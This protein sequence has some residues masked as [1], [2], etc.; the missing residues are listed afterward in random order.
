MRKAGI[1][2]LI[3]LLGLPFLLFAQDSGNPDVETDWDDFSSELY[4]TGDQS[5][6][7]SL[8]VGIPTIFI[9][10]GQIINHQ[11]T[12]P[13]GGAGSLVYNYHLSPS[14]FIGFDLG[15]KFLPTIG[16]NTLFLIPVG[17]RVGTQFSIWRFEFPIAF[18]FGLSWHNYLNFGYFNIFAKAGAAAF[19]R[20]NSEWSFGLTA[21]WC[22][23]PEWTSD[24]AKNV[25]GNILELLISARY[26]F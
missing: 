14:L 25:Y 15:L 12:P 26:H 24:P 9:N 23:F 16:G 3:S 21:N 8:G 18:T 1:L 2:V 17:G 4:V 19:F 6:I 22:L 20:V 10:N 5:F 13:V 11:I 7:I